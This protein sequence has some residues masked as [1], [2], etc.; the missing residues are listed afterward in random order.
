MG[1]LLQLLIA[2][3][4]FWTLFRKTAPSS[5]PA[6]ASQGPA[7]T[8]R[9]EIP[10]VQSLPTESDKPSEEEEV[11]SE[12]VEAPPARQTM[13]NPFKDEVPALAGSLDDLPETDIDAEV[14]ALGDG[15]V[16]PESDGQ[17]DT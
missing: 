2:G 5:L 14:E 6:P 11:E 10:D 13:L 7:G 16:D 15:D 9:D 8:T 1:G 3:V 12:V 4:T 17:Y